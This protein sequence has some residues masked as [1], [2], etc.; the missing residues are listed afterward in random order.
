MTKASQK[1]Y[2][3][4]RR[5]TSFFYDDFYKAVDDV[6]NTPIISTKNFKNSL[7][8]FVKLVEDGAIKG[9]DSPQKRCII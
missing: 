8:K 9:L 7:S 4:F 2:G 6:G 5:I 3:E 1:T